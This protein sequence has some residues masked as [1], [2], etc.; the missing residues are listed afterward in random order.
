MP[1]TKRKVDE[2]LYCEV[3]ECACLAPCPIHDYEV[4]SCN[5]ISS[6][7]AH[8]C[9]DDRQCNASHASGFEH[10]VQYEPA[11]CVACQ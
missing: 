4:S 8:R 2:M 10:F 5:T 3:L 9:G 6:G 1:Q 11:K 7:F